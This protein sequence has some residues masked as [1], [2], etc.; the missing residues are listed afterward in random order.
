VGWIRLRGVLYARVQL[1]PLV[2]DVGLLE[3]ERDEVH[4]PAPAPVG[5]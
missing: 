3:L 1:P 5:K 4:V 2:V